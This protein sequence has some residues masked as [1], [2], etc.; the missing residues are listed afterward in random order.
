MRTDKKLKRGLADLSQLFSE[1]ERS[2]PI[3][4]RIA[5]VRI[6]PP[7]DSAS[8]NDSPPK[9]ICS[10]FLQ[11]SEILRFSDFVG[12]VDGLKTAFQ[13]TYLLAVTPAETQHEDLA[14]VLPADF[15]VGFREGF[16][17]HLRS[18]REKITIGYIPLKQFQSIIQPKAISEPALNGEGSGKAL[19]VFDSTYSSVL[20]SN[21]FE[22]MDHCIFI[23]S[24]DA[25]QLMRTYE[26]VKY[27]LRKNQFMRY[28]LL[29]AGRGAKA[30]WEYVYEHFNEMVSQF[31]GC[32]IGF[33]G[34]IEN[35][36]MRL[37]PEL[38]LEESGNF[39]QYSSKAQLSGAL[40]PAGNHFEP[41]IPNRINH[42]ESLKLPPP[43]DPMN[44]ELCT[45][46]LIAFGRFGMKLR[47]RQ[48]QIAHPAA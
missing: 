4:R 23:T 48:F 27:C 35:R 1:G 45:L 14:H 30:L 43:E 40:W 19:A 21:V 22:L 7:Q 8:D 24:P 9:L 39:I 33:L 29:L 25:D 20:S 31:L 17:F 42:Q 16:D 47:G 44:E 26:Q 3:K 5:T 32:D 41:Q 6:E 15:C 36:E 38:L 18:I 37:N 11:S 10:T 46:E 2:V 34:W 28:S 13:E 12:L